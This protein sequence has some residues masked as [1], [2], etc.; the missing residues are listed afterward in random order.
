[1]DQEKEQ[2]LLKALAVSWA[3]RATGKSSHAGFFNCME[4]IKDIVP[5]E[6][7]VNLQDCTLHAHSR[8]VR[9]IE[10]TLEELPDDIKEMVGGDMPSIEKIE[11][12]LREMN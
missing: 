11:E 4:E 6:I 7:W 3:M 5:D 2:N 9:Y 8:L 12:K 10:E 1:M